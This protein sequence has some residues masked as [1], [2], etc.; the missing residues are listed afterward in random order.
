MSRFVIA[1]QGHPVPIIYPQG[2]SGATIDSDI[3]SMKNASHCSIFLAVG[4]QAGTFVAK[5]YEANAFDD[6][7]TAIATNVYKE[8]T[9][10]S[11][12]LGSRTAVTAADGITT[13]ATNN[14]FYVFEIDAED[15]TEGYPNIQLKL[16]S[17]DNTTYV[18]AWAV[19]SG[20]AFQ[21][22]DQPTE[23]A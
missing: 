8:E 9:T 1:E 3:V 20:Y 15:L 16:S 22:V 2:S 11:D 6:G 12:M 21:G 23:I 10:N 7:D 17:L 14:T 18:A 5:V 13:A 4:A 19:L